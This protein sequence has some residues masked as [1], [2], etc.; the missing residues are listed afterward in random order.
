MIEYLEYRRVGRPASPDRRR[1]IDH[2]D[3]QPHSWKSSV[4]EALHD[5]H[6]GLALCSVRSPA[7]SSVHEF[8][9]LAPGD[10]ERNPAARALRAS[11]RHLL[12]RH[13]SFRGVIPGSSSIEHPLDRMRSINRK[14]LI[15]SAPAGTSSLQMALSSRIPRDRPKLCPQAHSSWC[16]PR[17]DIIHGLDCLREESTNRCD[18][19]SATSS[20]HRCSTALPGREGLMP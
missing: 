2:R 16:R 13:R 1:P 15:L 5:R 19:R 6:Q 9:D 4:P 20:H 17:P 18:G 12:I 3:A 11:S 14:S 10:T 7:S 8:S